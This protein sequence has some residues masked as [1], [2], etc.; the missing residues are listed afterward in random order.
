MKY[1]VRMM[2]EQKTQRVP[3]RQHILNKANLPQKNT[4]YKIVY[5]DDKKT[6]F[7]FEL[8]RNKL[9]KGGTEQ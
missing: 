4:A 7:C 2:K 8:S 3:S 9:S 5:L 1:A 6:Q